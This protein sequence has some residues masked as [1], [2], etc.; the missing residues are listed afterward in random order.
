MM[1]KINK[2]NIACISTIILVIF[3]VGG[4]IILTGCKAEFKPIETPTSSKIFDIMG[5]D[6]YYVDFIHEN[7][8]Y[9]MSSKGGIIHKINCKFCKGKINESNNS[10]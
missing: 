6:M 5:C 8:E 4:A 7:H 9:L 1:N 10:N 2:F 3:F